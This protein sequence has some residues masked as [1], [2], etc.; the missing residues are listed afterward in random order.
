VDLRAWQSRKVPAAFETSAPGR[1]VASPSV[2]SRVPPDSGCGR[3]RLSG[4][5]GLGETPGLQPLERLGDREVDDRAE[6]AVLDLRAHES[7]E[8][9]ELVVELGAGRELH[10]VASGRQRLEDGRPVS[11]AKPER[12]RIL[13]ADACGRSSGHCGADSRLARDGTAT[14]RYHANCSREESGPRRRCR[15]R[16]RL[17]GRD[18]VRHRFAAWSHS[19]RH[20]RLHVITVA[21]DRSRILESSRGAR[22]RVARAARR[23]TVA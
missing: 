12:R 8:P 6:L 9:L 4:N 13:G 3:K 14:R 16:D 11:R 17:R 21:R 22:N 7:L 10:L 20:D 2:R 1:G 19:T 18:L 23:T 5:G 15:V